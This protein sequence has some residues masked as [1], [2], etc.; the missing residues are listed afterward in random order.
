MSKELPAKSVTRCNPAPRAQSLLQIAF[1]DVQV[2]VQGGA[3]EH[4]TPWLCSIFRTE[5]EF[6]CQNAPGETCDHA[7]EGE[8]SEPS[9]LG[10]GGG[11]GAFDPTV[12][13]HFSEKMLMW[14][15]V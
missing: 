10:T 3:S 15:N 13:Q 2:L 11:L 5:A 1:C 4:L 9:D 14:G 6:E 7:F 8:I 12:L